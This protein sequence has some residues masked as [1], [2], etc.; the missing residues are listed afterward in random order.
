[1][2]KR[3]GL[4]AVAIF[5]TTALVSLVLPQVRTELEITQS[6]SATTCPGPVNGA[7]GTALLPARNVGVRELERKSS[8]F[9][10]SPLGTRSLS[11]GALVIQGDPRST[12]T[13]QS[14]ARKW[15]SAIT[16]SGGE[17]TTYFVGGNANVSSQGKLVLVNSGLSDAT[18]EVSSFSENGE[19]Q[20]ISFSVRALTERVVKIDTLDPGAARL[21]LRVNVVNGRVTSF[22]TDERVRGLANNGGDYI[23]PIYEATKE[24]LVPGIPASFGRTSKVTHTL[25]IM[26]TGNSDATASVEVISSN[27]IFVP[28]GFGEIELSPRQVVDLPMD[29]VDFGRKPFALKITGSELIVAGVFTEVRSGSVSDFLWSSGATDFERAS[30]NLYGLEPIITFVGERIEIDIEWRSRTGKKNSASLS[31]SEILNWKVPR[32]SR[33]LTISNKS[34]VRAGMSWITSDGVAYLPIVTSS[35]LESAPRPISDIQVIQSRT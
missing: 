16:C 8:N 2:K 26:T 24:I 33:L 31:G 17:S 12:I 13:L 21:I 23:S 20:P 22:L 30:I 14:K 11:N 7:R 1:M 25:R 10:R 9:S 35:T 5:I 19:Q 32:D 29:D 28:V 18:V 3:R 34:G 15:T 6:Y 27:G 4:F